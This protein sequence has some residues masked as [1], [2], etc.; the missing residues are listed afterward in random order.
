M[1][2]SGLLRL[3]RVI[4]LI[5]ANRTVDGWSG[6]LTVDDAF[7]ALAR[8]H[9]LYP[10]TAF[11]LSRDPRLVASLAV[12]RSLERHHVSVAGRNLGI[13]SQLARLIR[14]FD[15]HAIPTMAF[16]GPALAQSVYGSISRREFDDLDLII[17]AHDLTN[18]CALLESC[19]YRLH[20]TPSPVRQIP[21]PHHY[22]FYPA[23][24]SSVPVELH[25][26]APRW[27]FPLRS[28]VEDLFVRSTFLDLG[29]QAVRVPGAEDQLLLMCI[30]AASHAWTSLEHV[31]SIAVAI[32]TVPSSFNWPFLVEEAHRVGAA[33]MLRLGLVLARRVCGVAIAT[34]IERMAGADSLVE[35]LADLVIDRLFEPTRPPASQRTLTHLRSLDSLTDQIRYAVRRAAIALPRSMRSNSGAPIGS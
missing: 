34:E 21:R 32:A 6:D 33:R 18:A 12:R 11:A 22:V 29:G 31:L 17:G 25:C 2:R 8:R 27:H 19:G 35:S 13:I 28:H 20:T 15:Q 24:A 3:L 30:H 9:R 26:G 10:I 23:L 5:N 16:K 14:V 4:A 1:P 7:L